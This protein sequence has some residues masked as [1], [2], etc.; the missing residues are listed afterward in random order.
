MSA[1][2][3]L[4]FIPPHL[5]GR[6][7]RAARWLLPLWLRH[8][9]RIGTITVNH[10]GR[11]TAAIERFEAGTSRLLL[12]FRH[13]SIDDPAVMAHLLWTRHGRHAQFLYDRGIPL[14]AGK[15][16]GW[17]FSRL[18]GISIQRGKLDLPAL[19]T[20]RELL[21]HGA[22]PFAIAPEGATNGHNELVSSLEPGIAQLSFWTA[23]A[24]TSS[25][26]T[27]QVE[28][29]PIGLQYFYEVPVWGAIESL[30]SQLE[31]NAGLS[32]P[33]PES[34]PQPEQLYGRLLRLGETILELLENFYR[35]AYR[36][37]VQAQDDGFACRGPG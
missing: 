19:R 21:L 26:R 23:A 25:G 24:L 8:Q 7:L 5:D 6:V 27:E 16:I 37:P 29:L 30:L 33:P 13:P 4:D 14:W 9:S 28:I 15:T 3:P 2:P 12:A 36:Q 32:P 31:N 1:G 10:S 11:L 18:G 35:Q 22:Y 34:N 20:A 17:L